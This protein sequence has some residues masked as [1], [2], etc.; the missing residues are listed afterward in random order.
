MQSF[1]FFLFP[2]AML[3]KNLH[4]MQKLGIKKKVWFS[5]EDK[6]LDQIYISQQLIT[7]YQ[8]QKGSENKKFL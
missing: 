1:N 4:N 5:E 2:M 7:I 8:I 3:V 6:I